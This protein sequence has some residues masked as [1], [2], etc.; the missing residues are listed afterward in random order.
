MRS[1]IKW[2]LK[3]ITKNN[4]F[5]FLTIAIVFVLQFISIRVNHTY[6]FLSFAFAI[7]LMLSF[8][9]AFFYGTKRTVDTFKKPTFLLESMIPIP[10]SKILLAKYL[11]AVCM[12]I[13]YAFIFILGIVL[14]FTALS[15]ET[16]IEM[17]GSMTDMLV[18]NPDFIFRIFLCLS[19][20]S[21]AFTS[22]VTTFFCTFKSLVP[23]QKG[24]SILS[25]ILGYLASSFLYLF[26]T[27]L[28]DYVGCID[29][30]DFFLDIFM[31][32]VIFLGYSLTVHLIENRLEIYG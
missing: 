18:K 9:L 11:I 20:Q 14:L 26:C 16:L 22:V 29:Y 28:A 25:F 13:L 30:T 23:S 7:I 4:F 32:V 31:I 5:W 21:I 8:F 17:F 1:Y 6:S 15:G 24:T 19:L 12:N 2:E 27:I 10:A 3:S